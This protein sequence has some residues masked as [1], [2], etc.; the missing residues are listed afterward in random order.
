MRRLAAAVVVVIALFG[1]VYVSSRDRGGPTV[2]CIPVV[3]SIGLGEQPNPCRSGGPALFPHSQAGWQIPASVLIG[4]LG[5]VG[6]L[7]V[8]RTRPKQQPLGSSE[9]AA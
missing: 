2:R 1:A 7:L 8:L 6:G 4:L 3:P 9:Q 5:V